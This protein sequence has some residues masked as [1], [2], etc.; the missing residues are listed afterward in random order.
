MAK[1]IYLQCPTGIAGDMCLGALVDLGV[2]LDY[3][4]DQLNGLG[5]GD[6]FTLRSQEVRRQ[7]Q[8]GLKVHVDIHGHH[9][10][11]HEHHHPHR[12]LPEIEQLIQD[13]VL[14]QRVK[15]W[16][17]AIFTRL[18]IAEGAVHGEPP[19]KVHF[20]EVGATD[21]LV[22][23]IGT[24]VGLD[25]L[26]VEQVYC[27]ALPTGG[28]TV[29]A[30]HG[31]MAVPV[32]AVLKL[33]EGRQVPV[34]DNGIA[35]ELVTPTGAAIVCT[36]AHHF[37]PMPSFYI[38]KTGWG[39]G[40]LDLELPNLL[41]MVMGEKISAQPQTETIVVL[42]TQIDDLSPQAIAYTYD[43]LFEAGAMDVF[44]QPVTMKKS[45]L[46]VLLTVICH[47]SQRSQC[48]QIIFR[49]T[50]TLGIRSRTEERTLLKREII[51]I[52]TPYGAIDLKLG[53]LRDQVVNV[54][55]EFEQCAAIARQFDLPWQTI[56]QA[57]LQAFTLNHQS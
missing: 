15:D 47:E 6:E 9:H 32:P 22:D 25:Y 11:D 2:P 4:R 8:R 23:I 20:H 55:P 35:K 42:E 21:A 28:G 26:D 1:V 34:Y 31:R 40:S 44:T 12:H 18:A 50:S 53:Y 29:K 56:H 16:S 57:A 30:A 49:E 13:S 54:Q 3:L 27:S 46:G 24:C 36:L 5:L 51:Q 7:T 14:P 19:E 17:G 45:R 10:H 52:H 33:W 38:E 39:A 37:G 41:R 43:L 48:E